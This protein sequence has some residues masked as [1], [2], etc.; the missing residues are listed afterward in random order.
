[1]TKEKSPASSWWGYVS[2]NFFKRSLV[3]Q[4]LLIMPTILPATSLLVKKSEDP[5]SQ[6]KLIASP[7]HRYKSGNVCNKRN[8]EVFMTVTVMTMQL[9]VGIKKWEHINPSE[10]ECKQ[11]SLTFS[12]FSWTVAK[13][14]WNSYG[15]KLG[16]FR[17]L[18]YVFP[19]F[20]HVLPRSTIS[21]LKVF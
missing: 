6:Q 2:T 21:E 10:W 11:L 9:Q 7:L 8:Y 4:N 1:M 19:Y 3:P 5:C 15:C 12:C 16:N 18:C 17:N 13:V 20:T 14:S